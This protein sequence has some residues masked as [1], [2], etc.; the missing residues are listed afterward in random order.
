V[1]RRGRVLSFLLLIVLSVVLVGGVYFYT[2]NTTRKI[3]VPVARKN[4]QPGDIILDT[5]DDIYW[6]PKNIDVATL[7]VLITRQ[8]IPPGGALVVSP[9]GAGEPVYQ[10][11][12]SVNGSKS[13]GAPRLSDMIPDPHYR[14][15]AWPIDQGG[16]FAGQQ[17]APG[18]R[19]DII[20]TLKDPV[21][22]D[23][24][25]KVIREGVQVLRI[26]QNEIIFAVTP[27][28]AEELAYAQSNG[29]VTFVLGPVN[30]VPCATTGTTY[31]VFKQRYLTPSGG[32]P[33]SEVCVPVSSAGGTGGAAVPAAPNSSG[34]APASANPAPPAAP[35]VSPAPNGAP[36]SS[37]PAAKPSGTA[38]SPQR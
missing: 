13:G 5:P 17:I 9:I 10:R 30:E 14:L 33:P 37:A 1:Q 11:E 2:T 29:Q 20:L 21:S 26:T 16:I 18:D 22:H 36:V 8:S 6:T 31:D 35:T 27:Q 38:S 24:I 3:L 28:E 25:T 34:P 19:L 7:G 12:I 23:Q 32:G 4:F 15:M